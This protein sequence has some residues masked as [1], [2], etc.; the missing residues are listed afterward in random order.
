[1]KPQC[2]TNPLIRA[3]V[4]KESPHQF[5]EGV[6]NL[7]QNSDNVTA[8]TTHIYIPTNQNTT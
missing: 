2:G 3:L 6:R 8:A 7:R 1:M 5:F 4:T